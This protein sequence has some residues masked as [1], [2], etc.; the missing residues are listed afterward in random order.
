M[1]LGKL[2]ALALAAGALLVPA[3]PRTRLGHEASASVEAAFAKTRPCVRK[4]LNASAKEIARSA[5]TTA[6]T[7][8]T[9]H[10]GSYARLSPAVLHAIEP[11]LAISLRQSR[12]SNSAY[13][14]HASGTEEGYRVVV[15]ASNGN[16][17]SIFRMP[18]GAFT[19]TAHLCGG[20][21]DW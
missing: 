16:T 20:W 7:Y 14:I 10:D 8:S 1:R 2:T 19:R 3:P 18:T 9:D 17:L 11:S 12:E 4:S 6:E 5:Q 21:R 13:L 15:R